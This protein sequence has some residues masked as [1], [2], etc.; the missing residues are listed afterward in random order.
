MNC[1][2]LVTRKTVCDLI[3]EKRLGNKY[4]PIGG[5]LYKTFYSRTIFGLVFGV[6]GPIFV[7]TRTHTTASHHRHTH[8]HTRGSE[9]I[10][11]KQW[12]EKR[13]R[14]VWLNSSANLGKCTHHKHQAFQHLVRQLLA[15]VRISWN[16]A[17]VGYAVRPNIQFQSIFHDWRKTMWASKV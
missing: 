16:M 4:Y 12:D 3:K 8:T 2:C 6:I 14:S 5:E 9:V 13:R 7:Y 11:C 17:L 1:L 10:F 15:H